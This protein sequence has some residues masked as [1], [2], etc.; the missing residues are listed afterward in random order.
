MSWDWA[1]LSVNKNMNVEV[2]FFGQLRE[3]TGTRQEVIPVEERTRL[4]NLVKQ[5]SEKYGEA[6]CQEIASIK[7]LRILINGRE[8]SQL[9]GM[10]TEL[11]DNN[12]VAFLPP[13][14]GG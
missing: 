4:T 10:D 9:D 7:E 1:L 3:I 11:K 13:I 6:F 12:T 14:M 2:L 5:L 8:Y